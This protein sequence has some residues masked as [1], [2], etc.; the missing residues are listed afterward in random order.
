[1]GDT[2]RT[3]FRSLADASR[4]RLRAR[5][6][7]E[8]FLCVARDH[9]RD[10]RRRQDR[11]ECVDGQC[12][13]R[14]RLGGEQLV[15]IAKARLCRFAGALVGEEP[16]HQLRHTSGVHDVVEPVDVVCVLGFEA[17]WGG[18]AFAELVP[19]GDQEGSRFS[20]VDG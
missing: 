14:A 7:F 5:E 18:E 3:R 17:V 13:T 2:S 9:G 8:E 1:M 20:D 15:R 16:G 19:L 12:R 10:G 4:T 11:F 6:R